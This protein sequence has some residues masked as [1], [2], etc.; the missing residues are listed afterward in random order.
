MLTPAFHF[1]ILEDLGIENRPRDERDYCLFDRHEGDEEEEEGEEEG[2]KKNGKENRRR[3][4]KRTPTVA[5]NGEDYR[6][7]RGIA[8]VKRT[9]EKRL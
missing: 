4:K 5:L 3:R 7:K 6:T 1:K 2:K 9:G 8:H